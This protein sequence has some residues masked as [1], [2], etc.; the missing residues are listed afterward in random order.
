GLERVAVRLKVL[1]NE[2]SPEYMDVEV[3]VSD[4]TG[5]RMEIVWREAHTSPLISVTAYER[6]VVTARMRGLIY[7]YEIINM[8]AP[9]S[10]ESTP[11][12][13]ET[14]HHPIPPGSFEEYD[15]DPNASMPVA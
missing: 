10:R 11:P 7:P 1:D 6:S 3:V 15:L 9:Q 4:R 8:L 12:G 5:S 13:S 14:S 2:N